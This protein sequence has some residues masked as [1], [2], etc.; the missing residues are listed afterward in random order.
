MKKWIFIALIIFPYFSSGQD[1]KFREG[2]IIDRSGERYEGFLR[3]EPGSS[4][5]PAQLFFREGKKG[6]TETYGPSYVKSFRIASDSFTILR[7][8]ALPRQ[9]VREEDFAKVLLVT[10]AGAIYSYEYEISKTSEHAA[11]DFTTSEE[12]TRYFYESK[13]KLV[14]ITPA[15]FRDVGSLVSDCPALKARIQNRKLK[16]ADLSNVIEDYKT[17]RSAPATNK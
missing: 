1:G 4:T 16:Y 15:N 6:K 8:I 5:R 12:N 17:C 11:S 10:P 13:G 2:F 14:L 7:K 3:F 9:K